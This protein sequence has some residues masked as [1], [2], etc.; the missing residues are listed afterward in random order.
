MTNFTLIV[1]LVKKTWLSVLEGDG[2]PMH[3]NGTYLATLIQKVL[4]AGGQKI[5]KRKK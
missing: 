3:G 1:P 2:T 4:N 5:P